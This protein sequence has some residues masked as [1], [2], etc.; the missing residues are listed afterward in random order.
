M[1]D[2]LFFLLVGA[3]LAIV[4]I[5]VSNRTSAPQPTIV[6]AKLP[7][8]RTNIATTYFQ[9]GMPAGPDDQGV[10]NQSSAWYY[11]WAQH[12]CGIDVDG[13]R[14]IDKPGC[15]NLFYAALPCLD[16]N[17]EMNI[18]LKNVANAPKSWD[19]LPGQVSKFKNRWIRVEHDG[20]TV[21][22]QWED[23]GPLYTNDCNYVFGTARPRQESTHAVASALDLSPAAF[24]QLTDG[25]LTVGI[26]QTNWQF[27][28]DRDVPYGPWR[29]NVTASQPDWR[30]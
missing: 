5:S 12:M 4:A 7:P 27:V 1:K 9:A 10:S 6:E 8:K 30:H 2:K 3:S 18:Q 22:V 28:S 24:K 16:T 25:D 17:K 13:T 23:V 19:F 11:D 15:D 20:K 21:Y 29:M 14:Q 26:I